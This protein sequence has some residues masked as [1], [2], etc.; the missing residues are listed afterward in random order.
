MFEKAKEA[1]RIEADSILEL[2][3]RVDAHF[4]QALDMILHC[5]GRSLSLRQDT[6]RC[7]AD[8]QLT[9]GQ[10]SIDSTGTGLHTAGNGDH[11]FTSKLSGFGKA[12]FVNIS[13]FEDQLHD[14]GT[15]TQINEDNTSFIT[16]FLYPA[17]QGHGFSDLIF[18]HF[19]TAA[20]SFQTHH[21]FSHIFLLNPVSSYILST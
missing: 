1:L 19:R 18:C 4:G 17:H 20:A 5:K 11:K 14:T 21:G 7:T 6:Q 2:I 12:F 3:P 13:V 15:V 8:L 9:C 16:G 10:I